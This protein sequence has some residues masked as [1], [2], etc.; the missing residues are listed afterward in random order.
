LKFGAKF[1]HS[2]SPL[3]DEVHAELRDD[4]AAGAV[5]VEDGEERALAVAAVGLDDAA[6]VL[7]DLGAAAGDAP[8]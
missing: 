1:P 5:A 3:L 6:P 7:V 4:L 8:V 2:R